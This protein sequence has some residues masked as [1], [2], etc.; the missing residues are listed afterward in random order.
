MQ[1][2]VP[3]YQTAQL[4]EGKNPVARRNILMPLSRNPGF[5]RQHNAYW[6]VYFRHISRMA[7][8]LPNGQINNLMPQCRAHHAEGLVNPKVRAQKKFLILDTP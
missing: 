6:L 4:R 7:L 8:A 3:P 1:G 2:R 5:S